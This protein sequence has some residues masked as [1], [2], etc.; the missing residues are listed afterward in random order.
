MS[1]EYSRKGEG[2]DE[3]EAHGLVSPV[4]GVVDDAVAA[5][6]DSEPEV[7]GH[8]FAMENV[9]ENVVEEVVE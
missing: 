8:G 7:E 9:V 4:E 3:V 2:G 5:H 1:D 6:D